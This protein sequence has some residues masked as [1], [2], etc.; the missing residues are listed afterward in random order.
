MK[1]TTSEMDC[2]TIILLDEQIKMTMVT[3]EML[4]KQLNTL[5]KKRLDLGK[6]A[7]Q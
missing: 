5:K 4:I 1:N 3:I 2:E 7:Q 6:D